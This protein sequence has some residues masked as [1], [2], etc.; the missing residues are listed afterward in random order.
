[1]TEV[2]V[3]TRDK[4]LWL[5]INRPAQR[6]AFNEAVIRGLGEGVSQ[7]Q[8]NR[9]IRAVVITGAGD[10]AFC[11]GGDLGASASGAP[12]SVNPAQPRNFVVDFFKQLENC[13]IPVIARVNGAALAGGLGLMCACDLAIAADTA[14]FGVPE[15]QIGLFPMMIMPYLLR[16]VPMRRLMDMCLTGRPMAAAEALRLGLVNEVVPAAELDEKLNTLLAAVLKAS[17]TAQRLG[18]HG[19][20]AMRDMSIRQAW[21]FAELMLP[22]MAATQDAAE[23]FKAFRER[24]PAVWTGE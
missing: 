5:T 22:M 15:A 1:M 2:L 9:E 20:H 24:R 7:A 17:P 18:K 8:Q 16:I 4:V 23:G 11:A 6:N 19:L 14:T 13:D 3:E 12:F 10:R 21:E